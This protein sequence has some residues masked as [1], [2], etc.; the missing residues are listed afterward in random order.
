MSLSGSRAHWHT[1]SVW[2]SNFRIKL[3]DECG[4]NLQSNAHCRWC[5]MKLNISAENALSC[6]GVGWYLFFLMPS[7]FTEILLW[8]AL[9]YKIIMCFQ[10]RK[11]KSKIKARLYTS[12]EDKKP[13]LSTTGQTESLDPGTFIS[14]F[15]VCDVNSNSFCCVRLYND[16]C[17]FLRLAVMM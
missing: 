12:T 7:W 13:T 10:K 9:G 1:S 3:G 2:W 8:Y 4:N 17:G 14:V 11:M 16:V 6:S 15:V 5:W